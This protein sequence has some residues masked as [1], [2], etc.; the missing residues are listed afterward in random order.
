M[1]SSSCLS[2]K[3][4][5]LCYQTIIHLLE[6]DK[7]YILR[8]GRARLGTL[9]AA[10]AG[11]PVGTEGNHAAAVTFRSSLCSSSCS[12]SSSSRSSSSC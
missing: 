10:A 12:N 5:I 3:E 2:P 7:S 4:D 6:K 8:D 1:S 11:S 9:A